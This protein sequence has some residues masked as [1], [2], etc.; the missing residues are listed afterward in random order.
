M[1]SRINR[2]AVHLRIF[3]RDDTNTLESILW[4][5]GK[6]ARSAEKQVNDA[7]ETH[8]GKYIA[9]VVA[10]ERM[11]IE[12]LLGCAFVAAQTYIELVVSRIIWL[13]QRLKRYGHDLTTTKE[14]KYEIIQKFSDLVPGT[15]HSKIELINAFANYFKHHEGWPQKW[16]DAIRDKKYKAEYTIPVI[17]AVGVSEDSSDNC[18]KG[19]IALGIDPVFKVFKLAEI[20]REWHTKLANAYKEELRL[21]DQSHKAS[22][23]AMN[24][25]L[26]R[27]YGAI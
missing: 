23:G 8:D 1:N 4:T 11:L 20:L 22:V 12:G 2:Y 14:D 15:R 5:L 13:H 16:D 21:L 25:N 10:E 27:S 18:H 17:R 24:T 19:L 26:K 3:A 9:E 6:A 7:A